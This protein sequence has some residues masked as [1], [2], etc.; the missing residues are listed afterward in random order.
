MNGG[1]VRAA[2]LAW[3]LLPATTPAASAGNEWRF[4]VLL[5]D[6]P[7]GWHSF[8]LSGAPYSQQLLSEARFQVK[9]LGLTVYTYSHRSREMWVQDCLQRIDAS[10]DDNGEDFRVQGSRVGEQLLLSDGERETGLTG[11]VMTFAYWNPA[12]LQ[13]QRLL[14]VQTG[15]YHEVDVQRVGTST[16]ELDGRRVTSLHYRIET[17]EDEI[18]LWY[19]KD[20]DWLALRSTT[21]GDRE[22]LYRRV[23]SSP[24]IRGERNE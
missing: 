16:L 17:G 18:D 13:Q 14:N 5:D 22:L 11:C 6:K 20:Y 8:S 21:R 23:P 7:I 24:D 3:L 4:Q 10:T 19:S 1:L 9:L 12:I 15:E 2:A